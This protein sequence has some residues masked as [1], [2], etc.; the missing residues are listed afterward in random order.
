MFEVTT[1]YDKQALLAMNK[2]ANRTFR[3]RRYLIRRAF[4]LIVG[5]GSLVSGTLLL[6]IFEKLDAGEKVLAAAALATGCLAIAEGLFLDR[7]GARASRKQMLAGSSRWTL[8]FTEEAFTGENAEGVR[9]TY[10]YSKIQAAYETSAYFL[11]QIDLHHCV[12]LDKSGFTQGVPAA[13]RM[14]I[15]NKTGKLVQNIP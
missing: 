1:D 15:G 12:I 5:L 11:L 8:R 2:V 9:S 6:M 13:F 14:F 3:R 10:P 4:L 7:L